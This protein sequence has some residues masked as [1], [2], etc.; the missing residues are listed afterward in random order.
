M[1]TGL[2]VENFKMFGLDG[3]SLALQPLN[4]TIGANA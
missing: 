2:L 3:Q 1:I 4:F